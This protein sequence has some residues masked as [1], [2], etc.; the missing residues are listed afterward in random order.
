MKRENPFEPGLL[1]RLARPPKKVA[2]LRASRIGDFLCA[3]PALRALRKGLPDAEITM[4]TL[5]ILADIAERSPHI[6][7]VALFPGF[8]WIAEQFFEA[9]KTVQ[10]LQEM[11]A[12]NFD[13]AI[14]IQGTGLFSNPFT[15]L[16]GAHATAGFVRRG[17]SAGL[18]DAALE[19]PRRHEIQTVLEMMTFLGVAEQGYE[20][21]FPL[22]LQDYQ[23]AQALVR[24]YALPLIGLHPAA[25]ESSRRWFVERF[26]AVG[27]QLQRSYGGTV[28]LLGEPE[29]RETG[30]RLAQ[31]LDVPYLNLIGK[32]SLVSLG[33][34]ITMLAVFITNDTGPAHIAYA[35]KAPTVTIFGSGKPATNG[36]LVS[37]PFR[38]LKYELPYLASQEETDLS[39]EQLL[40]EIS[41]EQVIEAAES[42]FVC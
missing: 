27:N 21:E 34:V 14:Q 26:A 41:V 31:M 33:A 16:L 38:I 23:D 5:P 37:G 18:L 11:Q 10:F 24:G 3:L 2:L 22:W 1:G 42:I 13:L 39:G 36:P 29:E 32:T 30:D 8:P 17:D 40:A 15:L 12:K 6:D 9:R 19:Y 25:R 28:L 35:L 20:L 4:I 7:S